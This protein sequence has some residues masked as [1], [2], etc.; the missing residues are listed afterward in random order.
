MNIKIQQFF[1]LPSQLSTSIEEVSDA[2]KTLSNVRGVG[3]DDIPA[4]L[5]FKC[6]EVICSPLCPIFN[7]PLTEGNFPAVWKISCVTPILK[8]DDPTLVTYYRLV[9]NLL[10]I[11]KLFE[12]IVLNFERSLHSTLSMDQHGFYPG[13]SAITS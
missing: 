7:K 1:F 8:S 12:L 4:F 3:P 11:S 5:L 6:S 9:S 13:R 10:F 2:I